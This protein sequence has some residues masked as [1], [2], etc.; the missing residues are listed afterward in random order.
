MT[1]HNDNGINQQHSGDGSRDSEDARMNGSG[2]MQT[3]IGIARNLEKG[4][5][6]VEKRL[7]NLEKGQENIQSDQKVIKT[8][9]SNLKKGQ[10]ELR[11]DVTLLNDS[12]T[13]YGI[14]IEGFNSKI[15]GFNGKI[16]GQD[17]KI[18]GQ[19]SKISVAHTKVEAQDVKIENARIKAGLWIIA[20]LAAAVLFGIAVW[21]ILPDSVKDFFD[22]NKSIAEESFAVFL[23]YASHQWKPISIDATFKPIKNL[24]KLMQN[25]S[26]K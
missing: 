8:D 2:E 21:G 18:A 11:T 7:E 16:E 23:G 15:E 19:D 24:G 26:V 13:A 14:Q 5:A 25:Y 17:S 12:V 20:A 6:S 10:A 3:L 9:I 4:Q 1:D 22:F